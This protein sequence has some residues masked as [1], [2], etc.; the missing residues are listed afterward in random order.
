MRPP[1][2]VLSWRDV[3]FVWLGVAAGFMHFRV[4]GRWL[5]VRW[6]GWF[7]WSCAFAVFPF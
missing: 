5:L 2:W 3:A 7:P 1:W 6:A 4:A